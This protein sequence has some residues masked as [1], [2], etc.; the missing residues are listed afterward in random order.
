MEASFLVAGGAPL[1]KWLLGKLTMEMNPYWHLDYFL[2]HLLPWEKIVSMFLNIDNILSDNTKFFPSEH[3]PVLLFRFW[4]PKDKTILPLLKLPYK[5]VTTSSK[6]K[7]SYCIIRHTC[8]DRRTSSFGISRKDFFLILIL[9]LLSAELFTDCMTPFGEEWVFVT[10]CD[11]RFVSSG[12]IG[13]CW[14]VSLGERGE[15]F[16]G[17]K[18]GPVQVLGLFVWWPFT[19]SLPCWF[20]WCLWWERLGGNE[21]YKSTQFN[22]T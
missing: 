6:E 8:C 18:S 11:R 19:A 4:I 12:K 3:P 13:V 2:K 20:C 9:E 7:I 15:C 21:K 14:L 22:M 5:Y 10:F 17:G 1:K 16:I